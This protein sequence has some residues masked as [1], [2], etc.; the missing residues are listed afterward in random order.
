M[1]ESTQTRGRIDRVATAACLGALCCWSLGPIF[2]AY[3]TGYVDSR[4]QNALRYSVACLFWL[5][6]LMHF[7][8]AGRFDKRTWRRAA[9]P[10]VANVAMQSLWATVFYYVGPAFAVLLTKTSVL[11][12]ATFSLVLFA[13][14]RPLARSWR[15]WGGMTLALAG[16]FGVLYFREDFAATRTATGIVMA[17]VCAFMWGLYTISVK[18]AFRQID[19]RIGFAVISIYTVV[20]LWLV[21]LLFG[22]PAQCRAMPLSGWAAVVI[23]GITAIALGHVFYYTAIKRIGATIPSLVILVQ[24]LV[25]F[26]VSSVVFRE[27]LN[28]LQLLFGVVLLGGAALS[29]WAQEHLKNPSEGP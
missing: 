23:S 15:F 24:P 14:E 5:P 16:V 25:V 27:R 12:V 6:V 28:G 7:M 26:S 18:V 3:L 19:S 9:L 17:L 20:G 29:V 2:I 13:D 4:T 8:R 11:W 1:N 10:S 21:A 22:E